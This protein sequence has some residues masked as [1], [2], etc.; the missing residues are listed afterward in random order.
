M[1]SNALTYRKVIIKQIAQQKHVFIKPKVTLMDTFFKE[2]DGMSNGELW[3]VI[4][5]AQNRLKTN[6]TKKNRHLL[7]T[8]PEINTQDEFLETKNEISDINIT[9]SGSFDDYND[10]NFVVVETK[11]L[12]VEDVQRQVNKNEFTNTNDLKRKL[13]EIDNLINGPNKIKKESKSELTTGMNLKTE[14]FNE[15]QNI[16]IAPFQQFDPNEKVDEKDVDYY[17]NVVLVDELIHKEM[18][19]LPTDLSKEDQRRK[20]LATFL[21][22]HSHFPACKKLTLNYNPI[23]LMPW[24]IQDFKI[25]ENSEYGR[26]KEIKKTKKYWENKKKWGKYNSKGN[27]D[28]NDK[29]FENFY[30]FFDNMKNV[31]NPL[32]TVDRIS[33]PSTVEMKQDKHYLSIYEYNECKKMLLLALDQSI[34]F[35]ERG[36]LFREDLLNQLVDSGKMDIDFDTLVISHMKDIITY[37]QA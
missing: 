35:Q 16:K 1:P 17:P 33:Y 4:E 15:P 2:L 29:Y 34:P 25:N 32:R 8:Q 11:F 21:Q 27:N 37:E 3:Q 14:I 13:E 6:C 26:E 18:I 28:Y 9:D 36:Y 20:N 10:E 5:Y 7:S 23:R 30:L 22:L 31:E 12:K 19:N 24:R